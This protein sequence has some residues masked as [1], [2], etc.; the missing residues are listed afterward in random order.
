LVYIE[1]DKNFESVVRI[2]F[3]WRNFLFLNIYQNFFIISENLFLSFGRMKNRFSVY[4]PLCILNMYM[5]I[6]HIYYLPRGEGRVALLLVFCWIEHRYKS[7][8]NT[9][10]AVI[11]PAPLF[12]GRANIFKGIVDRKVHQKALSEP[13]HINT[14]KII[15]FSI[16]IWIIAIYVF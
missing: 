5:Y 7:C 12:G 2:Y 10:C 3:T 8:D 11:L 1:L 16:K 4:F 9:L 6:M 14:A 15:D 13:S